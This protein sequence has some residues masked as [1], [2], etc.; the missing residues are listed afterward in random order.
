MS[1]HSVEFAYPVLSFF[2]DLVCVFTIFV[3]FLRIVTQNHNMINTSLFLEFAFL[4]IRLARLDSLITFAFVNY[5]QNAPRWLKNASRF[6][7][8]LHFLSIPWTLFCFRLNQFH[9]L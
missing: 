6:Y 1:T 9:L 4:Y 7:D 8:D 5:F 2:V 3:L